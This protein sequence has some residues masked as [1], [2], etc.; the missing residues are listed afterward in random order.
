M[1]LSPSKV[2]GILK[3]CGA[4][5]LGGIASAGVAGRSFG[6]MQPGTAS[7]T[8]QAIAVA[9]A[10]FVHFMCEVLSKGIIRIILDKLDR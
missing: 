1:L 7:R 5:K 6:I 2:S 3:P 10:F 4:E 8:P 9:T